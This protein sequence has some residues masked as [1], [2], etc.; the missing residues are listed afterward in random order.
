MPHIFD[1]FFI[2]YSV[3]CMQSKEGTADYSCNATRPV[4]MP[5]EERERATDHGCNCHASWSVRMHGEQ[6]STDHSCDFAKTVGSESGP[7]TQFGHMLPSL[8]FKQSVT[9]GCGTY[10]QALKGTI[11]IKIDV[12]VLSTRCDLGYSQQ[13][14]MSVGIHAHVV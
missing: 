1:I 2:C 14:Y 5:S 7:N 11:L 9:L 12:P 10:Y 4:A 6:G 3:G 8:N 13:I